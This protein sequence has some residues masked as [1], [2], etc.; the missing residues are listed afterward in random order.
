MKIF[1][2]GAT[3][4]IGKELV[5]V[6]TE[7]GYD[8]VAIARERLTSS[9]QRLAEVLSGADVIINL[10]GAPINRRWTKA[11]KQTLFRSRV[12]TTRHLAHAIN[13]MPHPP[14]LL[15]STSAVGIY[16]QDKTSD[17]NSTEYGTDF[18]ARLCHN[19][20]MAARE[21]EENTQV[22]IFR[23]GIV[24]GGSGGIIKTLRPLFN[25]GL[26]SRLGNGRQP[27]S[28]IH[29]DDLLRTYIM[30]I[31]T[32]LKEDVINLTAP[33][34]ITNR[35]FVATMARVMHRPVLLSIPSFLLR[36]IYGEAGYIMTTGQ[37]AI[38]VALKN[39]GFKFT[40]Q[41]IRS[42]LDAIINQ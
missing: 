32:P 40:H 37:W 9:P 38:P 30:A 39:I 24:L 29:I 26:G 34:P 10:S 21:A 31:E 2:T 14:R 20:E 18:L 17:E 1:I 13:L 6:L 41:N 19:W 33:Q 35:Q 42:A 36:L 7:R 5:S 23:L 11:Y 25:W 28:W 3:G 16:P 27:F 22:I 8:S 15:I 12:T 4:F